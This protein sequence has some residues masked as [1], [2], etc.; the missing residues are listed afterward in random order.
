MTGL[1]TI[2]TPGCRW[3]GGLGASCQGVNLRKTTIHNVICANPSFHQDD[4]N[5]IVYDNEFYGM[6]TTKGLQNYF[7]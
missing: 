1:E 4:S 6:N 2:G 5:Q 3:V 7:N